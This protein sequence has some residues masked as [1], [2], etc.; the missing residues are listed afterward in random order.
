MRIDDEQ[1][2]DITLLRK[3][4]IEEL[5]VKHGAKKIWGKTAISADVIIFTVKQLQAFANE[6]AQIVS[7]EPVCYLWVEPETFKY[8]VDRGEH[9]INELKTAYLANPINTQLQ[10]E[11]DELEKRA[12]SYAVE[13]NKQ[14]VK[15]GNA[16]AYIKMLEESSKLVIDRW[17]S[18]KWKDEPHTAEYI[19][20][21]RDA[22]ASRPTSLE[23]LLED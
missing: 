14:A 8:V 23:Q 10:T 15:L 18:P 19:Y 2:I 11:C 3:V 20:R 13:M 21:L 17:D 5:A 12:T 1:G 9:P 6:Y 22:L 4:D 7:S 16:V